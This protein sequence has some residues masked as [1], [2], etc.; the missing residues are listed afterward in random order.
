MSTA[1]VLVTDQTYF[2]KAKRTILDLRT[3]GEWTGPIVLIAVDFQPSSTFCDFYKITIVQFPRIP[4]EPFLQKVRERPL[5]IAT[6][7]RR[8]YEKVTQWEKLHLFD[9]YF[10]RYDRIVYLDAGLRILENTR[11]LLDIPWE[12]RFLAP[13]MTGGRI[14]N[15]LHS[16]LELQNWPADLEQLK[17]EFPGL[18][19]SGNFLNCMWIYD[20]RLRIAKQEFVDLANRYPLWRQNEM[21]VMNIILHLKHRC[22]FALPERSTH[23]KRLF[24]WSEANHPGTTWREYCCVKY[25]TTINFDCE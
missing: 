3:V 18:L 20:T 15:S 14:E 23:G 5:S 22:W 19:E 11:Y 4:M 1:F 6:H 2:Y 21:P 16:Q 24:D 7:D 9:E 13:D 8:E 17:H 25:A 12:R 10:W